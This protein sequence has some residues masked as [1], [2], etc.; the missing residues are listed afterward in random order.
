M[1]LIINSKPHN[2]NTQQKIQMKNLNFF[3]QFQELLKWFF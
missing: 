3:K 2:P 1:D